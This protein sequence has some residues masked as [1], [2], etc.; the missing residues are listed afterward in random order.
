MKTIIIY[1]STTGN[2]A[3]TAKLIGKGFVDSRVEDV[4]GFEFDELSEYDLIILGTSTAGAGEL[5][6]EWEDKIDLLDTLDLSEKTIA[7]FGTGDQLGYPDTFAGSLNY[8]YTKLENS[9]AKLVGRTSVEGYNFNESESVRGEQFVGLVIDDE[10]Q[11]NKTDERV[12]NWVVQI[13]EEM[14]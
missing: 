2:A 9:G 12:K 3:D 14:K 13:V 4:S 11:A 7:I 8:I 1:G 6:D 5:Q 10:N